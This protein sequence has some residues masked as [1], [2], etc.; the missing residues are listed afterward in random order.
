L[1]K[2]IEVYARVLPTVGFVVRFFVWLWVGRDGCKGEGGGRT[3][4]VG[5]R[6]GREK[7]W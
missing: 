1:W 2:S 3:G 5:R 7:A 6:H 4:V